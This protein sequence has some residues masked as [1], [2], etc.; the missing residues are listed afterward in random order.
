ML[1]SSFYAVKTRLIPETGSHRGLPGAREE[2]GKGRTPG[3]L[4]VSRP[5]TPLRNGGKPGGLLPQVTGW[6]RE[7]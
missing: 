2:V 6:D 1:N 4:T 5:R 3:L 7:I